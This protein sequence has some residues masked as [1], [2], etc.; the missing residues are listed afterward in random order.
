MLVHAA[1]FEARN[2]HTEPRSL[3]PAGAR[4]AREPQEQAEPAGPRHPRLVRRAYTAGLVHQSTCTALHTRV[5]N[6]WC[7]R[8]EIL[9]EL[10]GRYFLYNVV[11][12]ITD[13]GSRIVV[14]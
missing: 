3:L 9:G 7:T 11:H 6:G 14:Q 1:L 2:G 8:A 4:G 10:H 5:R 13:L 12:F